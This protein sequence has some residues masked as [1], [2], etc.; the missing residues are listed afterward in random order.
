MTK[1]TVAIGVLAVVGLIIVILAIKE[2]RELK[3]K[4]WLCVKCMSNG[5]SP[6]ERVCVWCGDDRGY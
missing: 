5:N 6:K 1:L 3:R 2:D 4:P